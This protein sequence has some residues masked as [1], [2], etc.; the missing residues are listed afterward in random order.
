MSVYTAY[1][2]DVLS[3]KI[4]AGLYI[5]Q[6]CQRF[7]DWLKREDMIFDAERVDRVIRFI[8]NFQH[9]KG[10]NAGEPFILSDWQQFIIANIYDL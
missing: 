10:R 8:R 9:Y 1:A 2:H 6:A 4:T 3:G 5:R 7:I